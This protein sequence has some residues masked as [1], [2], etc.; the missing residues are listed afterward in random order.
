MDSILGWFQP[1]QPGVD[2]E[3]FQ[4]FNTYLEASKMGVKPI[5][6]KPNIAMVTIERSDCWQ[7]L[8]DIELHR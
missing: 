2:I 8:T 6:N 3:R 7:F 4:P 1:W 5:R